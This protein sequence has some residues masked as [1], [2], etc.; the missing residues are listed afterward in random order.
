MIQYYQIKPVLFFNHKR[1]LYRTN[2]LIEIHV[3]MEVK[4]DLSHL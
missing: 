1:R 2:W 3:M 4:A